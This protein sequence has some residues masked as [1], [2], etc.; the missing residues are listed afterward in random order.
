MPKRPEKWPGQ[1]PPGSI[2]GLADAPGRVRKGNPSEYGEI[3]VNF[4]LEFNTPSTPVG[5]G[6]FKPLRGD[7]RPFNSWADP[8]RGKTNGGRPSDQEF[9]LNLEQK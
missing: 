6:E 9:D 7:R 4:M 5:Y 1:H 8:A 3:P 2:G